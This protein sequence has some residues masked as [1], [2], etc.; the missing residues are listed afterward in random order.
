MVLT[1]V[2]GKYTLEA[3]NLSKEEFC[4]GIKQ[5]AEMLKAETDKTED[6]MFITDLIDSKAN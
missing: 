4:N 3:K 1:R 6:V 5:I 2:N